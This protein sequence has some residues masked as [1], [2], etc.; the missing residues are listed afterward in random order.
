V[1]VVAIMLA[2]VGSIVLR[3]SPLRAVQMLWVNLIM[4]SLGSLALATE[5]PSPVLLERAPYGR[6]E[7]IISRKMMRHVLCMALFQVSIYSSA[8]Y[9]VK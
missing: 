8:Y 7:A 3:D 1:N 5:P 6:N 4:D 9:L 2:A